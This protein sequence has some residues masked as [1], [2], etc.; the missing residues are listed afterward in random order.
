M[1]GNYSIGI[2]DNT[3]LL[4]EG[5]ENDPIVFTS[6]NGTSRKSWG[7]LF[8]Y[9]SYNIFKWCIVE[10]GDWGL[11]LYGYP[12]IASNNIVENCEFRNN[13]QG[14]RMEKNDVNV[15]SC[16]IHD[17][18]HN[19]VTINNARIDMQGTRIYNGDRDGIYSSS[20]NLLNIYGSV[21]ENNGNGGTSTRNGI[22]AGYNDVINIGRVNYPYWSGYNTIRNNYS[23]EVYALSGI[24]QIQMMYN[25]VHDDDGYELYNASSSNPTIPTMFCW[26]GEAPPNY[27]QF[28]GNVSIM[29]ELESQPTWEGQTSSGGLSKP[30]AVPA[31]YISPEEQIVHLKNLIATNPKT[32]QADSALVSLFSIVRSDYVD[33][34]HQERDDFYSY[35][36]KLNDTYG[37]YSLGKRALQYMIVWK[38]L[39][40]ENETAIKLSLNALDCIANP[41][42]MGVMGNLV[43]LY[44]YS[45]QYDLAADILT[46]YKEQYKSDEASIEFLSASLADKKEMYELEKALAKGTTPPKEEIASLIPDKFKLYQAYPNP[47]N[48]VTQFGYAIPTKSQV[49]IDIYDLRGRLMETLV[50][51]VKEPGN[52][53]VAWDASK[54]PSGVYLYKIQAG[55]YTE[56]RKC[57]LIK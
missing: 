41:D 5:T 54:Y 29:D 56:T 45:D 48:P 13:D 20:G 40:N 36:S 47:F 15:I 19:V 25:S 8:V 17:N 7:T 43:N 26:W 18:R 32:T 22:L 49:R 44:T 39:A 6:T 10:Y 38:M 16:N 53:Q 50:N 57:L 37:K 23:S 52:Y 31:K 24:A 4:A 21:I 46:Q 14:L 33:N 12:D 51:Q 42:R 27:A 30:V 1:D 34:Q 11:K 28:Y 55:T 9:S 3:R 2:Y 35:L